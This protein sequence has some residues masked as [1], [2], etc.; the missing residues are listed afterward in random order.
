MHNF[1]NK[2]DMEAFLINYMS[3]NLEESI[4]HLEG[5]TLLCQFLS[6]FTNLEIENQRQNKIQEFQ[7]EFDEK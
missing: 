4:K 6:Y 7:R 1:K 3:K 2:E 5:M